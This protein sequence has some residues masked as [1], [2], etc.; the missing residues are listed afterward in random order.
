MIWWLNLSK[1]EQ[2]RKMELLR[3]CFARP[4][5]PAELLN[6]YDPQK[7]KAVSS[8]DKLHLRQQRAHESRSYS[9]L[10]GNQKKRKSRDDYPH[11]NAQLHDVAVQAP[12]AK[13]QTALLTT[14]HRSRINSE[15]ESDVRAHY[16]PL[17]STTSTAYTPS[18]GKSNNAVRPTKKV[19]YFVRDRA[20][21]A[22]SFSPH[23]VSYNRAILLIDAINNCTIE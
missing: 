17:F 12:E 6:K 9:L 7:P 8:G 22:R 14:M 2:K 20:G 18:R 1:E 3:V 5:K 21:L 4:S 16:E 15:N 10:E 11:T 13:V 19:R 23:D